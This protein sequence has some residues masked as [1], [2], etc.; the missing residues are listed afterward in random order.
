[1]SP[2]LQL[3]EGVYLFRDSCN[4]YAVRGSSGAWLIF[5]A[6]TLNVAPGARCARQSIALDLIVDGHPFGQVARHE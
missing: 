3:E 4:V 2:W 5:S 6:G 1:M